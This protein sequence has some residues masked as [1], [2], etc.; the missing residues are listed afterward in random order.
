MSKS[1]DVNA[2]YASDS[3]DALIDLYEAWADTY[4]TNFKDAQGY[5][6]HVI[7]AQA[8][9]RAGGNGPI[10]DVGAGTG[11]VAEELA[12]QDLTDV[13]ALDLS[14]DMLK[15]AEQKQLYQGL[16][17][18]DVTQPLT[19]LTRRYMGVVSAGTFTHGHVGP[20]GLDA[21]LDATDPGAV[22]ALSIN[23]QHF[24]ALGFKAKFAELAPLISDYSETDMRIYT[25]QADE[26]HRHDLARIVTFKRA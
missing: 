19:N 9:V 24:E 3:P 20:N 15:V 4:D 8:F 23:H 17:V 22:F 26:D 12:K 14:A 5:M 16:F 11:L 21:L 7:V 13:D 1:P 18:G 2:A 6:L 25:D 10:L